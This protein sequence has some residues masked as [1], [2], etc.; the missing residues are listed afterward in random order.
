MDI[1]EFEYNRAISQAE[2]LEEIA[3]EIKTLSTAD[4]ES[5]L[6]SLSSGWKGDASTL[7]I[8]KGYTLSQKG[9]KVAGDLEKAAQS[10]RKIAKA[11]HDADRAAAI[12]C[13]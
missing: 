5:A 6:E 2:R 12:V 7:F 13:T 9:S 1:I 10:I 11:I 8:D 3:R 4:I